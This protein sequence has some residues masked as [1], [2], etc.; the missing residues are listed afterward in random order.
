MTK[1]YD[2]IAGWANLWLKSCFFE[3]FYRGL[4]QMQNDLVLNLFDYASQLK[5]YTVQLGKVF[6]ARAAIINVGN[7]VCTTECER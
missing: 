7:E 2:V 1:T 4:V 3:T 5:F 6:L